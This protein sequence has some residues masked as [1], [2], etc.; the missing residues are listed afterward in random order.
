MSNG[1]QNRTGTAATAVVGSPA[2]GEGSQPFSAGGAGMQSPT[3]GKLA[4]ALAKAQ[5][6][7]K[8]PKKGN[9]AKIPGKEGKQGFEYSYADLADVIESYRPSLS[10]A[11]IAIV[12]PIIQRD[13]H[14]VLVTRLIHSSGEWIASEYPLT[15]Y[16]KPQEQ[17]SALTYARRYAVSA[18]LGIAAEDDDDGKRA[19]DAEPYKK[20]EPDELMPVDEDSAA[21]IDVAQELEQHTG[22]PWGDIVRARSEFSSKEGDALWF[23]DPSQKGY[24]L[25]SGDGAK[26]ERTTKPSAKWKGG[27]RRKL[28]D[29]LRAKVAELQPITD[30]DVPF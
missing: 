10:K 27:V 15:M 16:Q 1:E 12:Q 7:I 11:E 8:A 14:L 30:A 2:S 20:A 24:R 4:A 26:V 9:T 18:L 5:G 21:I 19:Q 22:K 13:G 25:P 17:G 29:D 3:I 28:E 6:E 23:E